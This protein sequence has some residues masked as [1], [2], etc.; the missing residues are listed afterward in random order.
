MGRPCTCCN[1]CDQQEKDA[2][3]M[4]TLAYDVSGSN[5]YDVSLTTSV[6]TGDGS[7][8]KPGC[9][10]RESSTELTPCRRL[11]AEWT[12]WPDVS[13]PAN[14]SFPAS[15]NSVLVGSDRYPDLTHAQAVTLADLASPWQ[16]TSTTDD[17]DGYRSQR[18][19]FRHSDLN[20]ANIYLGAFFSSSLYPANSYTLITIQWDQFTDSYSFV[21]DSTLSRTRTYS[22]V[23]SY[24]SGT[25]QFDK[26]GS[27][28]VSTTTFPGIENDSGSAVYLG[29]NLQAKQGSK[30]FRSTAAV[31]SLQ[32]DDTWK[33]AFVD[34]IPK[35]INGW[36]RFRVVASLTSGWTEISETTGAN[37]NSS[38]DSSTGADPVYFGLGF[39]RGVFLK[40]L[41]NTG[42]VGFPSSGNFTWTQTHRVSQPYIQEANF[43]FDNVCVQFT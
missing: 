6:L 1:C 38:L 34:D 12:Y 13:A 17:I 31:Q 41:Q 8:F 7:Y 23:Y 33:T 37:V 30:H 21:G 2:D 39:F 29:M 43:T 19:V 24:N 42:V 25:T 11:L 22:Q 15:V 14:A 5:V 4:T 16:V 36:R 32:T 3:Q 18:R 9:R 10:T 40:E 35:I 28:T 26:S 20:S 27:E